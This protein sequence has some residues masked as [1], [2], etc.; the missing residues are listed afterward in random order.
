MLVAR[1]PWTHHERKPHDPPKALDPLRPQRQSFRVAASCSYTATAPAP[2]TPP[3]RPT[4][5]C[6]NL[7]LAVRSIL[8]SCNQRVPGCTPRGSPPR[9][10]TSRCRPRWE[11]SH[12][13]HHPP[14]SQPGLGPRTATRRTVRS[15]RSGSGSRM[16]RRGMLVRPTFTP[17]SGIW[18]RG[19]LLGRRGTLKPWRDR[20]L[21]R[22]RRAGTPRKPRWRRCGPAPACPS[23]SSI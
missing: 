9:T 4:T 10:A 19:R 15:I 12:L 13:G 2:L 5:R 11:T 1:T 21:G 6:P 3:R 20:Q 7:W 23:I 18:L 8:S 22:S 16:M 14:A 17:I